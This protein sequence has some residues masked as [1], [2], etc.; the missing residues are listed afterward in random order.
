MALE[1]LLKGELYFEEHKSD[2]GLI[3][4]S[5]F[6]FLSHQAGGSKRKVVV[7]YSF[8]HKSFQEFFSGFYLA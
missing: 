5:K 7:R 1:S 6:G 4:L 8:L 3:V 2:G